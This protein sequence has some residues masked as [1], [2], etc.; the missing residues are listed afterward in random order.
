MQWRQLLKVKCPDSIP[1]VMWGIVVD[2]NM[3]ALQE[4][5]REA[6]QNRTERSVAKQR[7][8]NGRIDWPSVPFRV[9]PKS[10]TEFYDNATE[11][12]V[13]Q[14]NR[15]NEVGRNQLGS[16]GSGDDSDTPSGNSDS[17][18]GHGD[19]RPPVPA[20]SREHLNKNKCPP[21]NQT[22]GKRRRRGFDGSPTNNNAGPTDIQHR[23]NYT[24]VPDHVGKNTQPPPAQSRNKFKRKQR[25]FDNQLPTSSGTPKTMQRLSERTA[26]TDRNGSDGAHSMYAHGDNGYGGGICKPTCNAMRHPPRSSKSRWGPPSTGLLA[27]T[28]P[29]QPKRRERSSRPAMTSS[30]PRRPNHPMVTEDVYENKGGKDMLP[31]PV[32]VEPNYQKVKTMMAWTQNCLSSAPT[33]VYRKHTRPSPEWVYTVLSTKTDAEADTMYASAHNRRKFHHLATAVVQPID[34]EFADFI[35]TYW[36]PS[37]HDKNFE[38]QLDVV[39]QPGNRYLETYGYNLATYSGRHS[40]GSQATDRQRSMLR[41]TA[42][43]LGDGIS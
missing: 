6:S 15:A 19:N 42:H 35:A 17:D 31:F 43:L 16:D 13:S 30:Y 40:L 2:I 34:S 9:P 38:D 10:Y 33:W 14:H 39:H 4:V 21:Q 11:V 32:H 18:V 26:P 5:L 22:L 27:A 37:G 1:E 8:M 7:E 36:L 12:D 41:G 3:R 24:C 29:T 20:E 25:R 28:T 23:D